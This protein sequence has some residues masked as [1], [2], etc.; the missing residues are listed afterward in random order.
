MVVYVKVCL[1]GRQGL[2]PGVE[3]GRK[4]KR[5]NLDFFLH[6]VICVAWSP[7]VVRSS[8]SKQMLP[9]KTVMI[10]REIRS[11]CLATCVFVNAVD[12]ANFAF[13]SG[14]WGKKILNVLNKHYPSELRGAIRKF[15]ESLLR[16][17]NYLYTVQAVV[18][19]ATLSNIA[20]SG[21]LKTIAA[22]PKVVSLTYSDTKNLLSRLLFYF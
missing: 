21:I 17:L 14:N 10:L 2:V 8:Q 15:L 11:F 20:A 4:K 9:K 3:G 19:Q 12:C 7:R 22:D 16:M 18:R 5:E 1:T 13:A 6:R